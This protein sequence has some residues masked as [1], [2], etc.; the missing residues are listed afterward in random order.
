MVSRVAETKSCLRPLGKAMVC[1]TKRGAGAA[2]MCAA[3]RSANP[4]GWSR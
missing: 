2:E 1:V 3:M 4:S